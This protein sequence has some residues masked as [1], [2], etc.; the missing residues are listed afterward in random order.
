MGV[1][2]SRARPT[3]R[4]PEL[5]Q[6]TK[7]LNGECVLS[8]KTL[9]LLAV[10]SAIVGVGLPWVPDQWFE[11]AEDEQA[12]Q[13]N[14]MMKQVLQITF[15]LAGCAMLLLALVLLFFDRT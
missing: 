15:I 10:L 9:V 13:G 5:V 4:I 12:Q 1:V 11:F 3:V 14:R 6:V 8:V 7:E 2:Y